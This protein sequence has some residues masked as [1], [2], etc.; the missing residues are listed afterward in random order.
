MNPQD[1]TGNTPQAQQPTQPVTPP[2][3]APQPATTPQPVQEQPQATL[4]SI[5]VKFED[6]LVLTVTPEMVNDM[7]FLEVYSEASEDMTKI[8]KLLRF[9]FGHEAYEGV[10]KYYESK[11]QKFTITKMGEVFEKLESD[12]SSNPDFLRQ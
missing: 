11:G 7:R 10:F 4:K 5:E 3:T 2:Q 1:T 9:M 8:S 6:D 12:L